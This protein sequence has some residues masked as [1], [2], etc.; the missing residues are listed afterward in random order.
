MCMNVRINLF[1]IYIYIARSK[2][3]IA[4]SKEQH[5]YLLYTFFFVKNNFVPCFF[6]QC[7]NWTALASP[8]QIR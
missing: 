8:V 3:Y 4:R 6:D 2:E 7:A 5:L 1:F